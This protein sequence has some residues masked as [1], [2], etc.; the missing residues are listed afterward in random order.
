MRPANVSI[1]RIYAKV[2]L[3]LATIFGKNYANLVPKPL[4]ARFGMP[5]LSPELSLN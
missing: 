2:A 3:G 5:P 1:L 4:A